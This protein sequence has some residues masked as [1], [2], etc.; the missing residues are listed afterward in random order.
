[1]PE[2][3]TSERPDPQ[4]VVHK[5]CVF[6]LSGF[7][8]TG[9]SRYH[10]LYRD[11]A[12]KQSEVSGVQMDVG[13][14]QKTPQGNAFWQVSAQTPDGVVVTHFEFLRWDDIVRRHWPKN[15]A[16]LL[17]DVVATTWLN[18][19]TGAAWRMLKLA[20]PPVVAMLAAFVVVCGLL[21]GTPLLAALVFGAVAP[22]GGP[23]AALAAGGVAC[24]LWVQ[25]GRMLEKKY[26]LLW[27]MRSYAFTAQQAQGKVPQ[28]DVRLDLHA[29]TVLRRVAA[30]QD[31]EVLLV[32]HSSGAMMAV[33]VLA[34]VLRCTP[35]PSPAS[36]GSEGNE[37]GPVV[38]LLTLGQCMP[39]L[40][41][42]PQANGFRDDLQVLAGAQE[43]D[44]VDFTAPP[45]G[46]C[47]ALVDPLVACGLDGA[48]RLP[49]RPKLLS[50]KFADMFDAP[51]YRALRGD[52][53][54]VHFQYLMASKKP[55]AY[56]YF[57]ITAGA[58]TL[59]QRFSSFQSTQGYARFRF[60]GR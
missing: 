49:D 41:C 18:V 44:W 50:P 29:S 19:R 60:F 5:R 27:L 55:V 13:P 11:E 15:L 26:S 45:D 16:G 9:A 12:R 25:C 39:M 4:R 22:A 7:D 3:L 10:A 31:D 8:P 21:L 43:L 58:M 52:R 34:R 14:R 35:L 56:D 30:A 46:C 23:W 53:F 51:D 20:W 1:M 24:V 33:S 17:L 6:Y 2:L 32:G 42:L 57:A 40:A 47:F 48:A 28:L 54:R 37:G 38:S 36:A 59:A